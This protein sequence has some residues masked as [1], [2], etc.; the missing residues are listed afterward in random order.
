M[1]ISRYLLPKAET[2]ALNYMVDATNKSLHIVETILST[3]PRDDVVKAVDTKRNCVRC[4][5]EL[6]SI[7]CFSRCKMVDFA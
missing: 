2:L 5:K 7:N 3:V 4:W 6:D 1:S